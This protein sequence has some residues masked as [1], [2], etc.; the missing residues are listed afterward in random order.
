M[1]QKL[2]QEKIKQVVNSVENSIE[3][4]VVF[5]NPK[6]FEAIKVY[7]SK[8]NLSLSF[9]I[10]QDANL[11]RGDMR[12][13]SGSIEMSDIVSKKIKFSIPDEIEK[14]LEDAKLNSQK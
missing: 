4:I 1:L 8:N 12:I 11:E 3:N 2:F 10:N 5:L 13:K 7:N 9:E 6:D 14:D